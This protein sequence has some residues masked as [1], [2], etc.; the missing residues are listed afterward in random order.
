V[1]NKKSV[2]VAARA[3]VGLSTDANEH[4]TVGTCSFTGERARNRAR[5]TTAT[6]SSPK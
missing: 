4:K 2:V 3:P 5:G 6:T 1:L